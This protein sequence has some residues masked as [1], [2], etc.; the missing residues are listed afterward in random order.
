ML[1]RNQ[2]FLAGLLGRSHTNA[3]PVEPFRCTSCGTTFEARASEPSPCTACGSYETRPV[4]SDRFIVRG[5][6]ADGFRVID[7]RDGVERQI[8]FYVGAGART[9]AARQATRLNRANP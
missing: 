8:G 1:N 3:A 2:G 6:E 5:E 4:Q 7:R 9:L